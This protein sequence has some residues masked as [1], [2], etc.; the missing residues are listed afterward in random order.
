MGEIVACA[1][2]WI[3]AIR[4]GGTLSELHALEFTGTAEVVTYVAKMCVNTY[5]SFRMQC[6]ASAMLC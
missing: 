6:S 5:P 4:R 2:P 3:R 1:I